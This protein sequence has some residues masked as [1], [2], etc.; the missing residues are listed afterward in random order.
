[1]YW[2]DWLSRESTAVKEFSH[3][4][5]FAG[6]HSGKTNHGTS[7]MYD[8]LEN[9]TLPP[10]TEDT[11]TDL[12][13]LNALRDGKTDDQ[14]RFDN[15][16]T[17]QQQDG[18]PPLQTATDLDLDGVLLGH[19]SPA[20]TDTANDLSRLDAL[21][22]DEQLQVESTQPYAL[23]YA[24]REGPWTQPAIA[25]DS[26]SASDGSD[27]YNRAAVYRESVR[28]LADGA[29]ISAEDLAR[30]RLERQ[31]LETHFTRE[32][33]QRERSPTADQD[34]SR[35]ARDNVDSSDKLHAFA[36]TNSAFLNNQLENVH[37]DDAIWDERISDNDD[38]NIVENED[39]LH[40]PATRNEQYNQRDKLQPLTSTD[41][42]SDTDPSDS[43]V[44]AAPGDLLKQ[45]SARS[46][47]SSWSSQSKR[48]CPGHCCNI[49]TKTKESRPFSCWML[50]G[51]A[52]LSLLWVGMVIQDYCESDRLAQNA[53]LLCSV[54]LQRLFPTIIESDGAEIV[55]SI[56]IKQDEP[57]CKAADW[58]LRH[59]P[60]E[61]ILD[62]DEQPIPKFAELVTT[63][64]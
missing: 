2:Y 45:V 11:A 16:K 3:F 26:A 57:F 21:H 46:V 37:T 51:C 44:D 58:P 27:L 62:H 24:Q 63:C 31:Y 6:V 42:R 10:H 30:I 38:S 23:E 40:R 54:I 43:D 35:L 9:W 15:P 13:K 17:S 8:S 7:I 56:H 61:D 29:T 32:W 52:A 53:S 34:A 60:L 64:N 28:Q 48:A 1:M 49:G 59:V 5:Q 14:T 4:Q 19:L 20:A 33:K 55:A 47:E 12:S 36:V 39:G 50:F 22:D 18:S 41:D 25:L